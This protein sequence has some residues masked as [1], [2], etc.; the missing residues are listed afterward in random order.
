MA[1]VPALERKLTDPT[2][3]AADVDAAIRAHWLNSHITFRVTTWYIEN[4]YTVAEW[5]LVWGGFFLHTFLALLWGLILPDAQ[6]SCDR[7]AKIQ[8]ALK[9]VNA[10]PK[11]PVTFQQ[12][13]VD[14]AFAQS[15]W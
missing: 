4:T 1:G 15:W 5:H 12:G 2:E 3:E 14:F 7:I 13:L 11:E 6:A 10:K 9:Q 8:E